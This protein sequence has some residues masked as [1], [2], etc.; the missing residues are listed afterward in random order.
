VSLLKLTAIEMASAIDAI[1]ATIRRSGR[2]AATNQKEVIE[3]FGRILAARG[4]EGERRERLTKGYIKFEISFVDTVGL[5]EE[6]D[7]ITIGLEKMEPKRAMKVLG[8][9]LNLRAQ[10]IQAQIEGEGRN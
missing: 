7:E 9:R 3:T 1:G 2:D 5:Q 10:E 6:V 4:V 8:D